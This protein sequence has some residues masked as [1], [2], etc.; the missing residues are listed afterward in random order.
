MTRPK[1]NIS[2]W[3][4]DSEI[5]TF[6][7]YYHHPMGVLKLSTWDFRAQEKL[8]SALGNLILKKGK[9]RLAIIIHLQ[10]DKGTAGGRPVLPVWCSS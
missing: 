8:R 9:G 4:L 10:V 6:H 3:G 2:W 5:Y 7:K 1:V